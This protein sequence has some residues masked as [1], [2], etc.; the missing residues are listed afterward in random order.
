MNINMINILAHVVN[1][2]ILIVLKIILIYPKQDVKYVEMKLI[3]VHLISIK[4]KIEI[5]T[6]R[7]KNKKNIILYYL[8]N[9]TSIII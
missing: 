8:M 5:V 4:I 2:I 6:L 3:N 7:R 1:I 9:K